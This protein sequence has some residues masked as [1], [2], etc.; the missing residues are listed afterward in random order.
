MEQ[1]ANGLQWYV[2]KAITGHEKKVKHYLEQEVQR[3]NLEDFIAEILIPAEKVYEVKNGKKK[4]KEKS[5]FPGYIMINA[6]LNETR[7]VHAIKTL[8][9]VLGFLGEEGQ[10]K[11]TKPVALRSAEVKRILGR[12]DEA[13]VEEEKLETP[14]IIGESVKVIDGPFNT[15]TG[16]VEEVFAERK[17]L[18]VVV[19]IFGRN[20]PVELNYSQVEKVI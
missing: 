1:G 7:L 3:Q 15:F 11:N 14:F 10:G 8:P 2:V 16:T 19:K 18:N 4:M 20:T 13:V 5:F 12:V 9:G 6:D 17:K